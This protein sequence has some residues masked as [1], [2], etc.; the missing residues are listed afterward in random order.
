LWG[1]AVVNNK[2]E[3]KE[4]LTIKFAEVIKLGSYEAIQEEIVKKV[5][6]SIEELRSTKK[7]LDRILSDTKVN[8]AK[9]KIEDCPDIF[10]DETSIHSWQGYSR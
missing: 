6:R 4:G 2:G 9:S 1:K 8:I 7:L 5:F 3:D 10:R